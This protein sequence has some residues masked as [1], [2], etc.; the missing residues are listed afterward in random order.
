MNINKHC[1]TRKRNTRRI[2]L[3]LNKQKTKGQISMGSGNFRYSLLL[4][5]LFIF[6]GTFKSI[7]QE[8]TTAQDVKKGWTF[9][10][11]PA[12]A[13]DSDVGFKYGGLVNIYNY[14]DG[15][16]YPD[17]FQSIYLEW[18][19][20]TKSSGINQLLF[21][22]EPLMPE[23][24][25][26]ITI[27]LSYFTERSMD[28]YGF[29]GYE[30]IYIPDFSTKG[31]PDYISKMFYRYERK[32]F[33]FSLFLQ[34]DIGKSD[35]N[36]LI[37][38]DHYN[39]KLGRFNFEEYNDKSESNRL[40]DTVTLY[41]KYIDWGIISKKEANGGA[42]NYL[43]AG[44]IYDTR[45][46][47]ANPM[48]GLWSEIM[49]SAAPG[50]LGNTEHEFFKL[51]LI[52]RQYF[53]ILPKDLNL[54]LRL[55]YQGTIAGK[56]PFYMQSYLMSSYTESVNVEGLGGKKSLRGILR[57]RILGDDILYN[58]IELRWKFWRI[59]LFKQHFYFA[60]S[61]FLDNGMVVDPIEFS[62]ADIPEEFNEKEI[63]NGKTHDIHSSVGAGLHIA[64]NNNFVLA[65]D[66]GKALDQRDGND[67]IYIGMNFLY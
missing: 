18:S 42:V 43:K 4:I 57:N 2:H 52:H 55:G 62:K 59:N 22:S 26:R 17:Y 6:L 21:D 39:H 11:L 46:Q 47:K 20:T 67:G 50:F 65:I 51:A 56:A 15:S 25:F 30:S 19:R 38:Y 7:A 32:L 24:P 8:D 34:N 49:L 5:S 33:H 41:D 10:A 44:L 37:G 53:T 36:W 9:G 27:D 64:M 1:I 13:Y 3:S 31:D 45:D 66:Y 28:F 23:L 14:G 54:A 40:N 63:F 35:F 29:N 48:K 12:I 60:L 58:N 16:E 61:G